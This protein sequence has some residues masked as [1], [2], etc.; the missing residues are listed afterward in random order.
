MC[1]RLCVVHRGVYVVGPVRMPRAK[2]MAAVLACG[3]GAALSH[4]SAAVLWRHLAERS[5]TES[6]RDLFTAAGVRPT[7]TASGGRP[8][9]DIGLRPTPLM[10]EGVRVDAEEVLVDVATVTSPP[11]LGASRVRATGA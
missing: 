2:Q 11:Q 4:V 1:G 10:G 9:R 7:K 6:Q 8:S 5:G 3:Q